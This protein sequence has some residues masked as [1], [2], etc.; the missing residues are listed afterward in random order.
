M[1]PELTR[2]EVLKAFPGLI[3][4]TRLILTGQ[5]HFFQMGDVVIVDREHYLLRQNQSHPILD[6]EKYKRFS[7]L[8]EYGRKILPASTDL[9]ARY[10]IVQPNKLTDLGLIDPF[11]GEF[12]DQKQFGG[13]MLV[14]FGGF[15]TD[16]GMPYSEIL[17]DEDTF[18]EIR[19]KLRKTNW[20]ARDALFFT[21]G[22]KG[23]N[24][25]QSKHTVRLP[26]DNITNALEF[27]EKIKSLFP[28]VQ[29]NLIA[30]SLGGI[31][32]LEVARRH[33]DAI[34]NLILVNSPIRGI[35]QTFARRVETRFARQILKPMIGDEQ[36]SDYLFSLWSNQLH[37]KTLD[38][39]ATSFIRSGRS[40]MV[41]IAE[42]DPIVP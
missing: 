31:F 20:H 38:G 2:R 19:K 13:E 10:P 33:Q 34:N 32:A 6:L 11:S 18:V 4:A 25:Y 35:E 26:Q 21:Y 14:F 36:V 41:V 3:V 9:F 5:E 7:K 40:L 15:M 16:E 1:N 23:L 8:T 28:L 30:H 27:F 17:P 22:E 37:Q 42:D 24:K 29:F 12:K 39:F